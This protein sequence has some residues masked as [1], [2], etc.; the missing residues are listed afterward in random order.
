MTNLTR[1]LYR[2]QK[3]AE[4]VVFVDGISGC[5]KTAFSKLLLNELKYENG[6]INY[7]DTTTGKDIIINPDDINS[8]YFNEINSFFPGPL[9][10]YITLFSQLNNIELFLE[11][12]EKLGIGS[13]LENIP[14]K[15][16]YNLNETGTNISS[17]T[18]KMIEIVRS[19][20]RNPKLI[21]FDYALDSLPESFNSK[22]LDFAAQ[23]KSISVIATR[24]DQLQTSLNKIKL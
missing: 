13:L 20:T 21:I 12:S 7:L 8:A 9:S 5:G 17:R 10:E 1:K 14:G 6:S 23:E 3:L 22:L 15:L 11:I 19:L 2:E 24:K 4:N 16:S 18:L